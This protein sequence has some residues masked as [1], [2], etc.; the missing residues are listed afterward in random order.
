ML[1]FFDNRRWECT[2]SLETSQCTTTSAATDGTL[3]R[4][5]GTTGEGSFAANG[6]TTS[7]LVLLR[8]GLMRLCLFHFSHDPRSHV[9]HTGSELASC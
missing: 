4:G 5:P 6:K 7:F 8:F 1:S 2:W 9:V 3:I